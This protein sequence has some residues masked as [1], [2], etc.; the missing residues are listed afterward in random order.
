MG[1]GSLTGQVGLVTGAG[2]GVVVLDISPGA[3]GRAADVRAADARTLR[4]RPYG[5]DDPPA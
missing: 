4:L 3:V 5:P 1:T 2:R